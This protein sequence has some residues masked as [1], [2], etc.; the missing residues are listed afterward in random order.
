MS[1]PTYAPG[2]ANLSDSLIEQA[3]VRVCREALGGEGRVVPQQW[4]ARTTA[5]GVREDDRRRLDLVVYGAT[6]HGSALCCDVTLVS[7]LRTN[8]TPHPRTA[9]EDGAAIATARR[10]K[11]ERYPELLRPGPQRLVVLACEVGG[12]WAAECVT[13][14]V[15]GRRV[16]PRRFATPAGLVGSAGGGA[17]SVAP[18]RQRLRQPCSAMLGAAQPNPSVMKGRS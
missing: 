12:R 6:Q 13:S 8:G 11:R 2:L 16:P 3:W 17:C 18:N 14:C 7:P 15:F 1:Q 10:R 9:R 5:P 4:L